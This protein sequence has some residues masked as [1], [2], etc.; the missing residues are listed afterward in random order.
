MKL[1]IIAICALL[2]T[3]CAELGAAKSGIAS[4]GAQASDE[5]LDAAI[6]TLCN[7]VSVGAVKRRF[8]TDDEKAG[9]NS[10]CPELELP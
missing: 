6:W 5:T 9:Y 1:T 7:A 10:M 8:K 2:T 3:S 4:H